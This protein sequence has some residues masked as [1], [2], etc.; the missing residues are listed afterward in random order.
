MN[1]T[2]DS[3]LQLF[4]FQ[5]N[6]VRVV[7][8]ENEPWFVAKDVCLI[9]ELSNNREAVSKLRDK[10]KGVSSIDTPSGNQ[11]MT[12]ISEFGLYELVLSSRKP[13]AKQFKYWLCDEVIPQIRKTGGYSK[14]KTALELAKEQVK[15]L[16]QI[17]LQN[18]VIAEQEQDLIRQ[19]EVIDE[20]FNYSSIIRVAKF[21]KVCETK[22]EW[23]K[24]KAASRLMELEIKRVPCPRYVTKLL[25]HHDAWRYVY[26]ETQL[27]ETTTLIIKPKE[28]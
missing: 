26:P 28:G 25:Y 3:R 16:E 9:L 2:N 8:I 24:L 20:L 15:L 13:E 14:P 1:N 19:S 18:Q 10:D 11:Q 21:N 6:K 23:R 12:I 4:E 5:S 7:L 27:P 17:E 22:F